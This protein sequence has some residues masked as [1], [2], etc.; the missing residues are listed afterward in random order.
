[1]L[2]LIWRVLR[3]ILFLLDAEFMHHFTFLTIRFLSFFGSS[4]LK[5][6]SGTREKLFEGKNLTIMGSGLI[7]QKILKINGSK[8]IGPIMIV[9]VI[10]ILIVEI[11]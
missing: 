11:K 4:P 6:L 5:I 1:M 2:E 10:A 7:D 3:S 8:M 9:R